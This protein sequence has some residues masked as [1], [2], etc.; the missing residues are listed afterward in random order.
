VLVAFA[1]KFAALKMC[2]WREIDFLAKQ[3]AIRFGCV[4]LVVG[5]LMLN[6]QR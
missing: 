5:V 3:I 4:A 6:G 1:Y 2:R